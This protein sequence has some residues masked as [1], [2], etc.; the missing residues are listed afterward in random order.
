MKIL[1]LVLLATGAAICFLS[2]KLVVWLT[3][4]EATDSKILTNKLLG[5]L[6]AS[7]GM[8]VLFAF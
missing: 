1:G 6:I 4:Q 2:E 8:I 7:L 3:K 5:L